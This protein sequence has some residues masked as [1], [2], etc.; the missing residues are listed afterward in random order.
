MSILCLPLNIIRQPSL[1]IHGVLIMDRTQLLEAITAAGIT[2]EAAEKLVESL[3]NH[4]TSHKRRLD[5]QYST[6]VNQAKQI[7]IAETKQWKAKMAKRIGIFLE[8]KATAVEAQVKRQ[9]G[10]SESA[11]IKE[12]NQIKMQLSGGQ[13][14]ETKALTEQV[15]R[16]EE[17]VAKL[18]KSKQNLSEQY[19]K[20]SKIAKDSV[21]NVKANE[22]ALAEANSQLAKTKAL[23]AESAKRDSSSNP[24]N[25]VTHSV[26]NE[27]TVARP[28]D[29]AKRKKKSA[30]PVDAE[31]EAIANLI[32]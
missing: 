3:E 12:L 16:L 21:L 7:I 11:A 17:Q 30:P 31:I 1:I 20:M 22:K 28:N 18:Q 10:L 27:D 29:A 2:P 15:A 4:L 8:A 9:T 25:A 32:P 13:S 23:L 19:Q 24:D 5:E 14:V 26:L 6:K